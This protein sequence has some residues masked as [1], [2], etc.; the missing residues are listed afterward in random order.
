M[1]GLEFV[2]VLKSKPIVMKKKFCIL[3]VLSTFIFSNLSAQS[4]SPV[5]EDKKYF[6]G[7]T[8]FVPYALFQEPSPQYYQLNFGYRLDTKNTIS[9]EA[10]TWKYQA[11]LGIPYGPDYE[12]EVYNFP[13]E[14]QSFGLGVAYQRFLWKGLYG[15]IHSAAFLQNYLSEESDRDQSGFQLF[16]TL[17]VGYHIELFNQRFFLEPSVCATWW[18]INT[19]LPASFQ[20]EEDKWNNYFLFEPGLHFGINF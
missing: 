13:G 14:V 3:L 9:V 7:S 2:L 6:I 5:P 8:L 4:N 20:V 19:N 17:R 12:N 18:P 1:E 15:Q 11:P 10:I 16:N